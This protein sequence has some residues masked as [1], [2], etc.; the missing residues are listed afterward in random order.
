M[1]EVV[2]DPVDAEHIHQYV[3]QSRLSRRLGFWFENSLLDEFIMNI[4]EGDDENKMGKM[5]V[6]HNAKYEEL[7]NKEW[8]LDG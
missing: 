3:E 1:K 5:N 4:D 8:G 7:K 6:R 2:E